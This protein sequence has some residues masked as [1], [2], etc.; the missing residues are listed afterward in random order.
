MSLSVQDVVYIRNNFHLLSQREQEQ[1]I[2]ALERHDEQQRVKHC[3][4]DF[5]NYVQAVWPGFVSGAHHRLMADKFNQ[6]LEGRLK[7]L[8]INM[9]P[10]HTKSEFASHLFLTWALGK[11]PDWKIIQCSNKQELASKFGRDVRDTI[12]ENEQYHQIFPDLSLRSDS[13]ASN[14]WMTSQRGSISPLGW[15]ASSPAAARTC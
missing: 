5:L 9:P 12:L 7:R 3:H 2:D 15:T 8:I 4:D 1:A 6:V 14:R 13:K 11:R 10:R